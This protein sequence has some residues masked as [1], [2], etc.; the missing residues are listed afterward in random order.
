MVILRSKIVIFCE[1]VSSAVSCPLE[2]RVIIL[3]VYP[4][5]RVLH[6]GNPMYTSSLRPLTYHHSDDIPNTAERGIPVSARHATIYCGGG[7]E[8]MIKHVTCKSLSCRF[9]DNNLMS[10]STTQKQNH[11]HTLAMGSSTETHNQYPYK[12]NKITKSYTWRG[13][14]LNTQG[15]K[16]PR[17]IQRASC[18]VP[19]FDISC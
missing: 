4:L 6:D 11:G 17:R 7:T 16:L 15:L 2:R 9:I 8:P 18:L 1:Y 5:Y 19:D 13:W 10:C 3:L 14:S 12:N